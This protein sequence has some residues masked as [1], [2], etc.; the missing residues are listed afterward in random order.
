MTVASRVAV[1]KDG[2]LEQVDT[3]ERIYEFP[4]NTYVADFI[5]EVNLIEGR[6]AA[7]EGGIARLHWAEGQ[8]PI[9]GLAPTPAPAA[10]E[11][12]TLAIRP[13]KV[14]L[15]SARPEGAANA[16]RGRIE[17]IAYLGNISTYH[18]VLPTGHTLR[19]QTAN[20]DRFHAREHSWEEEV[21]L[22]WSDSAG[23]VLKG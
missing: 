22:S 2:R 13:E 4:A 15:S 21:W 5:G 10:G 11:K 23:L 12:V 18:V 9:S 20:T 16:V 3:P 17:D 6:L 19:A 7:V 8:A 14:R 1:M